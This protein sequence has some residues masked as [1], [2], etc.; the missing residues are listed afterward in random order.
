VISSCSS[1]SIPWT[2]FNLFFLTGFL[3]SSP[4][5]SSSSEVISGFS[6]HVVSNSKLG[7]GHTLLPFVSDKT[8]MD[9]SSS[10]THSTRL[11]KMDLPLCT[12]PFVAASTVVGRDGKC[13]SLPFATS[14]L[15]SS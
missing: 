2:F 12:M 6:S 7:V 10:P 5:V 11:V 8:D 1:I 9:G 4:A 3:I 13:P 15:T 14:S